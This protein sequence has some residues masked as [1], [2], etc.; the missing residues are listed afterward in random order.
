MR[1]ISETTQIIQQIEALLFELKRVL[2]ISTKSESRRGGRIK[3]D[4]N[5]Y[6]FSGLTQ[7]IYELIGEGFFDEPRTISDLQRKLK[8]KTI[9]KPT[10][11]LMAPLRILIIKKLLDRNKLDKGP[12]KYFKK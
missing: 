2:N 5:V 7:K 12:Y 6:K 3:S 10:T 4:I 8:D 9:N 11:S 1:K